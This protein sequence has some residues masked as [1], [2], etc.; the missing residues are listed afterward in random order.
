VYV[1]TSVKV[2]LRAEG[3]IARSMGK[4]KRVLDQRQ[5]S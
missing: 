3:G 1:G 5:G 2:E 4:A